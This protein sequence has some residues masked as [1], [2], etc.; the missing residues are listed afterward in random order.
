VIVTVTVAVVV[1][2]LL[3]CA[4]NMSVVVVLDPWSKPVVHLNSALLR[5]AETEK[6]EPVGLG[7]TLSEV[8]V[9]S[10][11][12]KTC[13]PRANPSPSSSEQARPPPAEVQRVWPCAEV[14]VTVT[15]GA[16]LV[17]TTWI[18]TSP[19]ALPP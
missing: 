2:P 19:L 12:S 1:P 17:F 7:L 13:T 15:V 10:G 18:V 16:R 5:S 8:I 9:S 6:L 4:V 11:S 14:S 3:S